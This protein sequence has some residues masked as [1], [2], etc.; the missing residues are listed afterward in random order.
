MISRT[1]PIGEML[2]DLRLRQWFAAQSLLESN[3]D[4]QPVFAH[5]SHVQVQNTPFIASGGCVV[6]AQFTVKL[7]ITGTYLSGSR[8]ESQPVIHPMLWIG[9]I[10]LQRAVALMGVTVLLVFPSVA[11]LTS[12]AS[13][14]EVAVIQ[15]DL[16]AAVCFLW[17][18]MRDFHRQRLSLNT[19]GAKGAQAALLGYQ[20][21][22][23]RLFVIALERL[24]GRPRASAHL[25]ESDRFLLFLNAPHLLLRK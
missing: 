21:L 12:K 22:A 10:I 16:I 18:P 3:K 6:T 5:P 24:K 20:G 25:S 4:T 14:Q 8:V 19:A 1:L 2:V 15:A 13:G 9:W 17:K 11:A 23:H 7:C